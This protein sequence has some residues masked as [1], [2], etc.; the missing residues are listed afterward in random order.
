VV[1]NAER[2][3]RGA[4]FRLAALRR[5]TECEARA[6]RLDGTQY[7]GDVGVS[8]GSAGGGVGVC[9]RTRDA[10]GV[11]PWARNLHSATAVA[12]KT[13]FGSRSHGTNVP[14]R[15][16]ATPR[17]RCNKCMIAPKDRTSTV[18]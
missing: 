10:G 9:H 3:G 1:A 14:L 6:N 2:S 15:T 7:F 16:D 12:R 11:Q 8:W 18:A 5:G 4:C 17:K 13:N